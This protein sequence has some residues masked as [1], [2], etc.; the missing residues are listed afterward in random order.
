MKQI[1]LHFIYI[2]GLFNGTLSSSDYI[3]SNDRMII[4]SEFEN[5]VEE[6]RYGLSRDTLPAFFW[7]GGLAE[8]CSQYTYLVSR[9]KYDP[10]KY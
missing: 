5:D 7:E 8:T 6:W 9:P 1:C 3:M 2:C 4:S 10:G